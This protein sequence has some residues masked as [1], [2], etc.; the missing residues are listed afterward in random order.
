MLEV[1]PAASEQ[2]KEYFKDKQAMPI[3]VFLNSGGW[4]GPSLAMALDESK[5]TDKVFNV[6]G[7]DYVVDKEF[8]KEAQ[9]IKVDFLDIGFK[10]TSSLVLDSSCGGCS[11]SGSCG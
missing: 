7:F 2:I 1:T 4:G 3:R 5:D 8:L 9:P 11:S 6:D 10:V